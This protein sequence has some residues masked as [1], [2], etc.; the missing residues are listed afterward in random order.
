[1]ITAI[2]L[3]GCLGEAALLYA[4]LILLRLSRKLGEVTKMPPYYR[5]YYVSVGLISVALLARM[6]SASVLLSPSDTIPGWLLSPWFS[7]VLHHLM[8]AAGLTVALP[9]TW[10]YW[11]WLLRE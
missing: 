1:M 6:L 4:M 10:K 11:G 3:A 7:V 5:G 8:L 9:I 2:A